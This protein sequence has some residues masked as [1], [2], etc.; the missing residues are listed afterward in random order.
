MKPAI[1]EDFLEGIS[2][3]HLLF[4]LAVDVS[5]ALQRLGLAGR[6]D[7]PRDSFCRKPRPPPDKKPP[8][9]F[10][11]FLRRS[12]EQAMELLLI[13]KCRLTFVE[14]CSRPLNDA[15][16]A[17]SL[18]RMKPAVAVPGTQRP[19]PAGVLQCCLSGENCIEE[20]A[21]VSAQRTSKP[22]QPL[23]VSDASI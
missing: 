23:S 19:R 18:R 14:Q 6:A 15:S 17:S 8:A 3:R 10:S 16:D 4:T 12:S 7:P 21:A 13:D 11:C 5:T 22:W 2:E 1:E 9:D 20:L